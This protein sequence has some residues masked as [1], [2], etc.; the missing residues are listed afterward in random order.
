[1]DTRPRPVDLASQWVGGNCLFFRCSAG[2]GCRDQLRTNENLVPRGGGG[3]GGGGGRREEEDGGRR[4]EG[5]GRRLKGGGR[6]EKEGGGSISDSTKR[7][8]PFQSFDFS[9]VGNHVGSV[10]WTRFYSGEMEETP[11]RQN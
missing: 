6:R 2:R 1:M 8:L 7:V 11:D 5:E 4:K 9:S 3:G 10:G